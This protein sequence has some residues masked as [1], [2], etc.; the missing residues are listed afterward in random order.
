M[1]LDGVGLKYRV[2]RIK[3]FACDKWVESSRYCCTIKLINIE[4]T[5]TCD[6]CD[7]VRLCRIGLGGGVLK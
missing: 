7:K 1:K 6:Y 3:H 5:F 4:K 2:K